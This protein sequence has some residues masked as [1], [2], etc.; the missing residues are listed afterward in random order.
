MTWLIQHLIGLIVGIPICDVGDVL[1]KC[2]FMSGEHEENLFM[3]VAIAQKMIHGTAQISMSLKA[4]SL[5]LQKS[6]SVVVFITLAASLPLI[7]FWVS[8]LR[9][10]T[11]LLT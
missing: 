9:V 5:L 3:S 8:L 1:H 7:K 11:S 6:L 10:Q 4:T 2:V